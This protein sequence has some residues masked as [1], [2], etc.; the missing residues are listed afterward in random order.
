MVVSCAWN[1]CS[2]VRPLG[3]AGRIASSGVRHRLVGLA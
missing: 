2:V 1:G 3:S